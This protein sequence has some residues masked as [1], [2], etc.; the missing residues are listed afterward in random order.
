ME[1]CE[2]WQPESESNVTLDSVGEKTPQPDNKTYTKTD[3]ITGSNLGRNLLRKMQQDRIE[4][5]LKSRNGLAAKE[6]KR[7]PSSSEILSLSAI[8]M[9]LRDIDLNSDTSTVEV[10]NHL[11]EHGRGNNYD[12]GE[13]KENQSSNS[14]AERTLCGSNKLTDTMSFTDSVLNST[15]F[16]HLQQSISRK[17]LSPNPAADPIVTRWKRD[18]QGAIVANPTTGKLAQ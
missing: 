11:W 9:A 4:T 16:R 2:Q 14:H 17:P 10:V 1:H 6:T 3:A 7:P 12:D 8:D 13:N 15:D 18:D 5:A